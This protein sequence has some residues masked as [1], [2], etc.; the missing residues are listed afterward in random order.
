M[1]QF[2]MKPAQ[3][4]RIV[5]QGGFT[6]GP[7]HTILRCVENT[8]V[9]TS[10]VA[11]SLSLLLLQAPRGFFLV[12]GSF[13]SWRTSPAQVGVHNDGGIGNISLKR[14]PTH[15]Y[16]HDDKWHWS[17]IIFYKLWLATFVY[18]HHVSDS[19]CGSICPWFLNIYRQL[20]L[21]SSVVRASGC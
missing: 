17:Y 1:S 18:Y 4:V 19:K 10:P 9:P 16:T 13:K 20:C 2:L 5:E 12:R 6:V 3:V 8:Q 15:I 14:W 11:P 7:H 21:C